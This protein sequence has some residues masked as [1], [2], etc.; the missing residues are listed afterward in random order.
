MLKA[1]PPFHYLH[2]ALFDQ[3]RG[4]EILYP[5]TAVGDR[6]LGHLATLGFQQVGNRLERCGLA[7]AI[8]AQEGRYS[9]FG[10]VEADTLE[11][12][13]DV[14]VDHL[15]VVDLKQ[16]LVAWGSIQHHR[17]PS[18]TDR[19]APS[20]SCQNTHGLRPRITPRPEW[21]TQISSPA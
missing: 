11:H 4:H 10:H 8:A 21:L 3:I 15:D 17:S 5:L 18:Q 14:I 6:T 9:A 2:H 19:T 16:G 1:M 7:R 13:N 12:E 20:S